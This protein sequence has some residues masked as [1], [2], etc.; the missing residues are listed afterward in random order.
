MWLTIPTVR[1]Q[2][3]GSKTVTCGG[4][5]SRAD[6]NSAKAISHI[7]AES[8]SKGTLTHVATMTG[9]HGTS[10]EGDCLSVV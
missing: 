5:S 6:G 9:T 2:P 8:A 3:D 10:W 1:S 4:R 7:T